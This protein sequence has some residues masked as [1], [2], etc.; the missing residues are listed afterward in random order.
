MAS[1][2]FDAGFAAGVK[3]TLA[4]IAFIALLLLVGGLIGAGIA[5]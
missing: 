2:E 4:A 1:N 5:S 3:V